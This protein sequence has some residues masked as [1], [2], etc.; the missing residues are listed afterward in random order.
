MDREEEIGKCFGVTKQMKFYVSSAAEM[1]MVG[2]S[3]GVTTAAASAT[4]LD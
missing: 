3:G 1:M 4:K 2:W